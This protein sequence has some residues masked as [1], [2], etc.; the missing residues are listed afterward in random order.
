MLQQI[1]A[2]GFPVMLPVIKAQ[3]EV[4]PVIEEGDKIGH[5]PAGSQFAGGIAAPAP[6]IFE[7]VKTIMPAVFKE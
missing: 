6:L 5:E 2:N 7:F 3:V 4:P 1:S